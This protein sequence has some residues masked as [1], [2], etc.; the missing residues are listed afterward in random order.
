MS[1][2]VWRVDKG[3]LTHKTVL[4]VTA[5]LFNKKSKR[6]DFT[7]RQEGLNG[8]VALTVDGKILPILTVDG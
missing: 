3:Y 4:P 5:L 8:G 7:L 1:D 2:G 6:S